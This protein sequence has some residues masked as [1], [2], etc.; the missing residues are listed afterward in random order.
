MRGLSVFLFLV[1]L[2]G[3]AGLLTP[4]QRAELRE[5]AALERQVIADQLASGE[6][7]EAEASDRFLFIDGTE[8]GVDLDERFGNDFP[9]GDLVDIGLGVG[10]TLLGIPAVGFGRRR[11]LQSQAKRDT[12]V[13][14]KVK[15]ALEEGK[16]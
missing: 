16:Q 14:A 8:F 15:A 3:C 1:C 13:A 7:T 2:T 6:I 11:Y 10:L 12:E 4:D 5:K 9:V